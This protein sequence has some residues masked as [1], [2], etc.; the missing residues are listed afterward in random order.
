MQF[1]EQLK[2]G[3]LLSRCMGYVSC[4]NSMPINL[5]LPLSLNKKL[6]VT[7]KKY[8]SIFFG[9]H[10]YEYFCINILVTNQG[11]WFDKKNIEQYWFDKKNVEQYEW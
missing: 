1:V 4:H 3:M 2:L 10:I 7:Y 11:N 5:F 6:N 8:Q 9:K